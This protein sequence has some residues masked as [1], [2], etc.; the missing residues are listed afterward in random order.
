MNAQFPNHTAA[1]WADALAALW[2]KLTVYCPIP[3]REHVFDVAEI[4]ARAVDWCLAHGLTEPG[5][6]STRMS[7]AVGVAPGLSFASEAT[8][9]AFTKYFY[10]GSLL[11][12]VWDS[13]SHDLPRITA[14][15][16]E[17]QRV[18]FAAA[19]APLPRDRWV[20]SLRDLRAEIEQVLTAE[21]F[22]AFQHENAV[23]LNG[24]L[25]Y[26]AVR[27]RSAPLEVGEYLRMRWVKS[28]VGTMVPFTAYSAYPLEARPSNEP[29]L[30][31]FTEAV[32]VACMF[33]NDLFSV[34]KEIITGTAG[35]NLFTVLGQA[36]S[37]DTTAALA[38]G[39]Q[40]FER[41]VMLVLRLQEQL[42][43]DPRP[44]VARFAADL[45]GWIPAGIQ[46]A[47]NTARYFTEAP[48]VSFTDTPL[49]WDPDDFTPPPYPEI[50]WWWQQ[51]P[52]RR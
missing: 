49:L 15:V 36:E 13:G 12:D 26:S 48:H 42:L 11:D 46:F 3:L 51:L 16:G 23:W 29:L 32:M 27:Q 5:S 41:T 4:D 6:V 21:G 18:M 33:I 52:S 40:L 38:K 28:G 43:L 45:P 9:E 24:Q 44:T 14:H 47:T 10:W 7:C 30:Q 31:A 22:A 8:V 37:L 34:A 39:W 2:Q 19:E 35:T 1:G 25:W 50:A 20:E 17:L